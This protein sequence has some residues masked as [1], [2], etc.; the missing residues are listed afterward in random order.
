MEKI[1]YYSIEII[2]NHKKW[3]CGNLQ[4]SSYNALRKAIKTG[5]KLKKKK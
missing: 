3:V 5:Y 2:D 4:F 1:L